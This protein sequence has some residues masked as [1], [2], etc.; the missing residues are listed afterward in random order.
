MYM[1]VKFNLK[2]WT[3]RANEE[4]GVSGVLVVLFCF[5]ML[6]GA[7]GGDLRSKE[8]DSFC[9]HTYVHQDTKV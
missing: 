5:W 7:M 3:K 2:K 9:L 6:A 4:E 8:L 1:S